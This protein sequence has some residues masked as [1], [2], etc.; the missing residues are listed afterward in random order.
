MSEGDKPKLEI[1]LI[2]SFKPLVQSFSEVSLKTQL[3]HIKGVSH[4]VVMEVKDNSSGSY[5]VSLPL[6]DLMVYTGKG[7]LRRI[8]FSNPLKYFDDPSLPQISHTF[9]TPLRIVNFSKEIF[10]CYEQSTGWYF[11]SMAKQAIL[12]QCL[13]CPSVK[14]SIANMG[15]ARASGY[16]FSHDK[17]KLYYVTASKTVCEIMIGNL[18]GESGTDATNLSWK[19]LEEVDGVEE[20]ATV[21]RLIYGV[22]LDGKAGPLSKPSSQW[23]KVSKLSEGSVTHMRAFNNNRLIIGTY[24]RDAS[25]DY[26]NLV[27]SSNL[28]VIQSAPGIPQLD[29]KNHPDFRLKTDNHFRDFELVKTKNRSN[30]YNFIV[31]ISRETYVSLFLVSKRE[32]M[33]TNYFVVLPDNYG[34]NFTLCILPKGEGFICYTGSGPVAK[35]TIDYR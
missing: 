16:T 21:G 2:A 25:S 23:K 22:T 19:G 14:S 35:I 9:S 1:Y 7:Q 24:S 26:L 20:V 33:N 3:K 28:A 4:N 34:Y 30:E 11:Y 15:D 8:N 29:G 6:P 13:D 31:A 10:C 17:K 32:I 27:D 12:G 5:M 18:G